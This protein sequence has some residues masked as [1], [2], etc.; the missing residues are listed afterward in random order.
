VL[1]ARGGSWV[2]LGADSPL[3][4]LIA[5]VLPHGIV[6]LPTFI[7]SAALG[8]RIGA[9]LLAPPPGFTAGQN[10]LWALANFAKIWLLVL[11][12][13]VA[14]ASLIE[15]LISPLVIRFFYV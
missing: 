9:A 5:Y 8:L 3:Q 15:G 14:L 4:F 6:E 7:L 2:A 11:L 10:L 1:S 13:L 12:P